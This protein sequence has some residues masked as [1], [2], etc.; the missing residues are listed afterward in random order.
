MSRIGRLA[1]FVVPVTTAAI[2]FLAASHLSRVE[3]HGTLEASGTELGTWTFTPDSCRSGEWR[4]FFGA[5]LSTSNDK[6]L[7]VAVI[8]DPL[9]GYAIVVNIPDT[10][11]AMSFEHCSVMRGD[12]HR[13]GVVVNG[14]RSVGRSIEVSCKTE[15]ASLSG[16][17]DFDGCH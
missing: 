6:R 13:G 8:S 4:G 2:G 15:V 11:K 17:V 3:V 5:S 16:R 10:D 9:R 1:W 12:V 7:G 14:I